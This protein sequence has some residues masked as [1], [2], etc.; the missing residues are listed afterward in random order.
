[1]TPQCVKDKLP[2]FAGVGKSGGQLTS[3]ACSRI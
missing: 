2:S 3:A 1:V